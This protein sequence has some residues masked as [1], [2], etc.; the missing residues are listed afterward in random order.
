MNLFASVELHEERSVLQL[1]GREFHDFIAANPRGYGLWIWKPLI[2]AKRLGEIPDGDGL[3]Y[4]DAGCHLNSAGKSILLSYFHEMNELERFL[5]CFELPNIEK[6]WSKPELAS[7][8]TPYVK[9]NY[10]DSPQRAAGV[11]AIRNGK[12][13]RTFV[14]LWRDLLLENPSMLQ[15][16]GPDSEL[17]G[18]FRH[19]RHDQSVFSLLSKYA[20]AL[21]R[22]SKEIE[23]WESDF[24]RHDRHFPIQARRDR[25]GFAHKVARFMRVLG[26]RPPNGFSWG[27]LRYQTAGPLG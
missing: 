21:V 2:I 12:A 19:H 13:A 8:L 24:R 23:G 18:G 14:R 3:L 20:E 5:L 17:P 9:Q 27:R 11:V 6:F 22:P 25:G 26:I 1:I 16:P 4:V 10:F 15:D 7:L